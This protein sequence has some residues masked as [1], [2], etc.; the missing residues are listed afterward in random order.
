MRNTPATSHKEMREYPQPDRGPQTFT[1]GTRLSP[2]HTFGLLT[3][4][5]GADVEQ[6]IETSEENAD[7]NAGR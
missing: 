4:P 5:L 3:S 1:N 2:V 7:R 6:S